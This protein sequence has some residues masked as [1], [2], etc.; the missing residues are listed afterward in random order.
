MKYMKS[1]I[2]DPYLADL[3]VENIFIS[4]FMP[5]APGEFV[6]IYLYGRFC[7]ETGRSISDKEM[8]SQLGV[9]EDRIMEAWDY[10]ESLG[11]IKKRYMDGEGRLDFVVE[12]VNLK[13]LLYGEQEEK[14]ARVVRTPSGQGSGKEGEEGRNSLFGNQVFK[15]LMKA[16][17]KKL[18]RP[19]ST[20]ELQKVISWIEDTKASPEVI[21]EGVDYSIG[22][23]KG[24]F[25]YIS[26][27]VEGWIGQGLNSLEE[28]KAHIE[29]FDQ[30]FVRHRR[31]MQSLGLSRNPTEEERRIMDTWFDDMGYNMTKVL[32][33]CDK[34]AGISNPNIKYVNSVLVNKYEEAKKSGRDVNERQPV[35]Q[36]V[37]R[38]YYNYLRGKADKEAEERKEEVYQKVPE[39]QEIDERMRE[40]GINLAK[41][42]ARRDDSAAEN[43]SQELSRLTED[44]AIALVDNDYDVNYTDARYLC[45]TCNDTGIAEMGG[46]C[47]ICRDAR[48]A[49]AEVWLKEQEKTK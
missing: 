20:N 46:P 18:G 19:L 48:R 3:F 12:F 7:A 25:Q 44:R 49:E 40:I 17:E 29:E 2:K 6:K 26:A 43:L 32:E 16:I 31:V 4:E 37:L 38:D 45:T 36:S 33:A 30:R 5:D 23:G 27:V 14:Q 22:K 39:I 13:E 8:T 41:A 28:V 10:W 15:D 1:T 24:N 9:S 42:L 11:V 21:L 34:T 35:S 47:H